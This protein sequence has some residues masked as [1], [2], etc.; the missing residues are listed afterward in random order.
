M[1]YTFK[2][3]FPPNTSLNDQC[4]LLTK[5][6]QSLRLEMHK[7][8]LGRFSIIAYDNIQ[9]KIKSLLKQRDQTHQEI[10]IKSQI[11]LL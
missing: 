8:L 4:F 6:M 1:N 9:F 5:E 7:L 2:L 3:T 10:I 11:I